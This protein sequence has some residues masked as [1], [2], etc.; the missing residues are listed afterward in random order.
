[1]EPSD[2]ITKRVTGEI[3]VLKPTQIDNK[4]II[5]VQPITRF[6]ADNRGRSEN[7]RHPGVHNGWQ[8]IPD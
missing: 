5:K 1:M 7:L 2:V 3:D 8:I 4:Q 6:M